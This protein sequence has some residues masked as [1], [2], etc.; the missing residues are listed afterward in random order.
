MTTEETSAVDCVFQLLEEF[1]IHD[2]RMNNYTMIDYGEK[3]NTRL[4]GPIVVH[5]DLCISG[6]K[7]THGYII[8]TPK[9]F[10]KLGIVDLEYPEYH[11]VF[12]PL[13]NSK[14]PTPFA[15]KLQDYNCPR[16][17]ENLCFSYAQR[18][19]LA[20]VSNKDDKDVNFK[21]WTW[22]SDAEKFVEFTDR[23][24]ITRIKLENLIL[25]KP[26]AYLY[27]L[28]LID[29]VDSNNI[30]S[31]RG[32]AAS[33][34]TD[35][36]I[37]RDSIFDII[38]EDQQDKFNESESDP[39]YEIE[40]IDDTMIPQ[41]EVLYGPGTRICLINPANSWNV[42][43]ESFKLICTKGV[44]H[45]DDYSAVSLTEDCPFGDLYSDSENC[46]YRFDIPLDLKQESGG[47]IM[48][49][50]RGFEMVHGIP[51]RI[52]SD[53]YT[54]EAKNCKFYCWQKLDGQYHLVGMNTVVS[55][56]KKSA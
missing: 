35:S 16:I 11:G 18:L 20:Y 33:L 41:I 54:C 30:S 50:R 21:A 19:K 2:V 9:S 51:F 34:I 37:K 42:V 28:N 24:V 39:E 29:R 6:D 44:V 8:L 3:L 23:N 26:Y 43:N 38:D 40:P 14:N 47:M 10:E 13:E 7:W 4:K 17:L 56:A 15:K 25:L 46:R 5:P 31:L 22:S 49:E 48:R 36:R 53:N 55:C 27:N 12:E 52:I 32:P 1:T 45:L